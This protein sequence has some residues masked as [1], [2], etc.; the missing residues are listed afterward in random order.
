M[1]VA[2]DPLLNSAPVAKP[3]AASAKPQPKQAEP[4]KD[5]ASSFANVYAKERQ[6][7]AVD[8]HEAATKAKNSKAN[9][10]AD[11]KE[12]AAE[13]PAAAT[14][15]EPA[16]AD[17][18]NPLPTDQA[19]ADPVIDPMILLAMAGQQ[20]QQPTTEDSALPTTGEGDAALEI[21]LSLTGLA[22]PQITQT[23][24]NGHDPQV[25]AMS[26]LPG[27]DLVL[28]L[29]AKAQAAVQ[30]AGTNPSAAQAGQT[31]GQDFA[32]AMAQ[33]TANPEGGESKVTDE[34]A[35][36]E[37]GK[38]GIEALKD[39]NADLH[40]DASASKLNALNQ[41]INQQVTQAQRT[42]LVPGAPVSMQQGVW[43]DEV[44]DKVMWMSSQNLKSADIALDPP[45]LGR[46][47]VRINMAQDAATQVTFASPHMAVRDAVTESMQRLRDMFTQQGMTMDVN[48]SDQSLNRGWNGQN[49]NDGQQSRGDSGRNSFG[50]GDEDISIGTSEIRSSGSVAGGRGLVDY[51]A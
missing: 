34:L 31:G 51:Y 28:D 7:K 23:E 35:L 27:V 37:Q 29:A 19:P 8:R 49:G 48:V 24:D 14:T 36:F 45:D 6:D 25:D 46:L 41:A 21:P 2:S 26:E 43:T 22:T 4:S 38:D 30:K 5:D 9:D 10:K 13:T 3:Q 44:V 20:M 1:S 33:L 18:G 17:S 50:G 12:P 32:A 16:V 15:A 11:D 42:P 39:S 47:E 40:I